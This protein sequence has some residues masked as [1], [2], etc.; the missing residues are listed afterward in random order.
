MTQAA[1]THSTDR[2]R[3]R[4]GPAVRT[5]DD[6]ARLSPRELGSLYRGAAMPARLEELD[7]D[8]VG[9]MLA[10]RGLGS[11]VPLRALAAFARGRGFPWGG[12]S[13]RASE[14]R[15]GT[16]INRVHLGGRH[17]LF[18]FA[19][20]FGASVVDGGPAVILD[21]DDPD[22]PG[23]IRAI[24]DEVREIVPGLFFGPACWKRDDGGT[25]I[26]LWFALD[27]RGVNRGARAS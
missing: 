18:P 21:Y 27:A 2:A 26:V 16:G 14:A 4:S 7:G 3:P 23:F 1:A 11:G 9:R 15:A 24:H 22:N 5:L 13:F 17:R 20:C 8:L 10:V 6:L 12:K 25:P 19:T